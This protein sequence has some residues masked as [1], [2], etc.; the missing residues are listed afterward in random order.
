MNCREINESQINNYNQ[1]FLI[2]FKSKWFK[3]KIKN[4]RIAFEDIKLNV[5]PNKQIKCYKH[6]FML[7]LKP[8]WF[9]MVAIS[10]KVFQLMKKI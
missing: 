5:E 3:S 4:C 8:S 10:Y 7:C 2:R 9:N 1:T 6:V